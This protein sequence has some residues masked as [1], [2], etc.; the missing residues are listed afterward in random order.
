MDETDTERTAD[1][2]ETGIT[3]LDAVLRGG[4]L[5]R[6]VY[7]V[8]GQPG[9]GKT[10]LASHICFHQ[11]SRG[12][13][14]LYVTLLSE[15]HDRMLAHLAQLDFFDPT[16]IPS[17]L[18]YVSGQATIE[19]S[20][21]KGLSELLRREV[22][23][24]HPTLI[25][26][27]GF[28]TV[29]ET[30]A[31]PH[32]LKKFIHEL[33]IACSLVGATM[34]LLTS[35]RADPASPAH[36]MVDGV[37]QLSD[38]RVDKRS[39]RELE[40]TKF[41]GSG[42]LK[43]G[44]AFQITDAGFIVHPRLESVLRDPPTNDPCKRERLST[45]LPRLDD[46]FQGGLLCGSSTVLFGTTGTG[47]TTLGL[48]F[49]NGSSASEPG[50]H[51][52]FFEAPARV[53]F[54]S[55]LLGLDLAQKQKAGHLEIQWHPS[56]ERVL[57]ALG[58]RLLTSVRARGVKRLF[59]DG[60]DGFLKAA[61]DEERITH[62]MAALT[63]ELRGLGVTALYTSE[64]H[65]LFGNRVSLPAQ[66]MSSLAENALLLRLVERDRQLA[67]MLTVIKLRDS[68]YDG[69]Q[70]ELRIAPRATDVADAMPSSP[71]RLDARV[72]GVGVVRRTVRRLVGRR[73]PRS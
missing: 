45:G 51:F 16:L 25:V 4:L 56:T 63:N 6:S 11:A 55:E 29:E 43:G 3:G 31:T 68:D 18:S 54:K 33:Q 65:D 20:G 28:V 49:L 23:S 32:E 66:G 14:A 46:V 69:T 62:F 73:R 17:R 10:I 34:L 44:H 27:D 47:K 57:D 9:A 30:A 24:H 61:A 22:R 53:L 48:H 42:Y 52:G 64:L 35:A 19:Q 70:R 40:L 37:I 41:R 8:K 60:F 2:M 36:A 12:E 72:G 59:V 58:H 71:E 5:P 39:E 26:L 1:R 38:H 67:R 50:L 21:L 15:T 13:R 7:L